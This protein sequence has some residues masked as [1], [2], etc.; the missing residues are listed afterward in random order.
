[1]TDAE[2]Q[3]AAQAGADE[4]A[5]KARADDGQPIRPLEKGQ[6]LADGLDQ[7]QAVQVAGDQLGD[8]LGVGVAAED[9]TSSSSWRLRAA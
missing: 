6:G 5:G 4:Q 9:H 8:H 7:V 2:N 1:M 3:G